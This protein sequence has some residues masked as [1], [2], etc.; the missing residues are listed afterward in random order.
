[1]APES[2]PA[3]GIVDRL[4]DLPNRLPGP[5]VF[6]FVVLFLIWLLAE[7]AF[8]WLSGGEAVGS[9]NP[10]ISAATVLGSYALGLTFVLKRVAA[11]ASSDFRPAIGNAPDAQRLTRRLMSMPDK[12]AA[13]AI[14]I[15]D[16]VI[17]TGYFAAPNQ[18]TILTSPSEVT[19]VVGLVGYLLTG[20]AV[21]ILLLQ[22]V[23]QLRGVSQLHA[24]ATEVDLF[25]PSAI[26]AFSRLTAATAIGILIFAL[27]FVIPPSDPQTSSVFGALQGIVFI[28]LAVASF[29]LPL[30]GMH[31][32]L[33]AEKRRLLGAVNERVKLTVARVHDTVDS[34]DLGR[35]DDLQKTLTS[36]LS[37][38]DVENKLSTWPWSPDTFRGFASALALPVI[39][40]LVIRVLERV[41]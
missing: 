33:V 10:D 35:A 27:P 11:S 30:R 28:L 31:D 24:A 22:T 15:F 21:A 32:R 26:N 1:V 29:A 36:L 13:L 39:I 4:I 9:F 34:D 3:P 41:V 17:T 6:W 25:N 20:A 19:I 40:W 8:L 16:V 38:R 37:E 2:V 14:V 5:S 7:S 18:S 12:Q 23:R